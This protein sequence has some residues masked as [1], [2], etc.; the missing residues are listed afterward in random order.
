[1]ALRVFRTSDSAFMSLPLADA[2]PEL[3]QEVTEAFDES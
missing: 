3:M 2:I 1:M